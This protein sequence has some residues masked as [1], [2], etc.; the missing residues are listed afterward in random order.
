LGLLILRSSVVEEPPAGQ[1]ETDLWPN[2]TVIA[3]SASRADVN[4]AITNAV[5]GQ[6]VLIPDGDATWTTGITT[7]KQILIRAQNYSSSARTSQAGVTKNVNITNDSSGHLFSMTSGS[8]YHIG[9]AGIGFLYGTGDTNFIRFNGSTAKVP[10]V[11]DISMEVKG[12]LGTSEDVAG[13]AILGQGT[14]IWNSQ[15]YNNDT[16]AQAA[17]AG[18][19][20]H[21]T[22]FVIKPTTAWESESTLGALDTDGTVNVYMED[23]FCYNLSEFPDSDH[24]ARYVCRYTVLDGVWGTSHG[25]SSGFGGRHVDYNHCTFLVSDDNRNMASKYYWLRGGTGVFW[26][27]SYATAT[28]DPDWGGGGDGCIA[29]V[30]GEEGENVGVP[31]PDPEGPGFGWESGASVSDPVW[32]WDCTGTKAYQFGVQDDW[33]T[34]C[35]AERDFFPAD[36]GSNPGA[37]PGY[38]TF[39]YPHP[40]RYT[41]A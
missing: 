3:A 6:R 31:Y 22:S 27:N 28:S 14:V 38:A 35:V 41:P 15:F 18:D 36:G 9:I 8:T 7:T 12:G 39:E 34:K 5:D 11:N 24:Q 16:V 37:K 17:G 10:L 32:S 20:Q 19:G 30:Y 13:F 40:L 23:S 33:T 1:T 21:N 26:S 25:P 29:C 2:G 4:T